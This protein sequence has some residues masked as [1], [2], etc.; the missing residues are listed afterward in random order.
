MDE[1]IRIFFCILGGAAGF[2]LVGAVFGALA[3][4]FSQASGQAAGGIV[5]ASAVRAV[6]YVRGCP[7]SERTRDLLSGG[8]DGACFLGCVGGLLGAYVGYR[9]P[10]ETSLLLDALGTVAVLALAAVAFGVTGYLMAGKGVGVVALLF[11]GG[12]AGALGGAWLGGTDGL[13]IGAVAGAFLGVCLTR[14]PR[15]LPPDE[16]SLGEPD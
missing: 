7:L 10:A 3:R 16:D 13:L 4:V 5:G 11:L 8:S 12:M 1:R 9:S 14:L 15:R 2:G 6:E